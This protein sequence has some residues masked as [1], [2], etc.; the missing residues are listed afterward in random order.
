MSNRRPFAEVAMAW[1]GAEVGISMSCRDGREGPGA[2]VSVSGWEGEGSLL[3]RFLGF[4][5]RVKCSFEAL[6]GGGQVC[7]FSDSSGEVV[8]ARSRV[9]GCWTNVK[10]VTCSMDKEGVT[11]FEYMVAVSFDRLR[12]PLEDKETMHSEEGG[13]CIK[14]IGDWCVCMR[15]D[16]SGLPPV[17]SRSSLGFFWEG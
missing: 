12:D 16:V 17:A 6:L 5:G 15:S 3:G 8:Y 10:H 9:A 4:S 11:G 7:E 2:G 14:V 1:A 13:L